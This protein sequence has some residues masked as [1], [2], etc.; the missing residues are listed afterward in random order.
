MEKRDGREANGE[1]REEGKR[2]EDK[3]IKIGG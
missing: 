2:K 1:K 3:R